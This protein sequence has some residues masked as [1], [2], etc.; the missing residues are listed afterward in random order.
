[1]SNY[2]DLKIT[3]ADLELDKLLLESSEH[4]F[5]PAFFPLNADP[6]TEYMLK[7]KVN[8]PYTASRFFGQIMYYLD[9][10][11]MGI[12]EMEIGPTQ[13]IDQDFESFL[14]EFNELTEKYGLNRYRPYEKDKEERRNLQ[15]K[16][17]SFKENRIPV[18]LFI[19]EVSKVED[20]DFDLAILDEDKHFMISHYPYTEKSTDRD[21]DNILNHRIL[22]IVI[23]EIESY[24][25]ETGYYATILGY[26]IKRK[27]EVEENVN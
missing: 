23:S 12:K 21:L 27:S 8:N 15:K 5:P 3:E 26:G 24:K 2:I 20:I 10:N 18:Y 17:D 22:P 9:R 1:M 25:I 19:E 7:F 16:I 11:L 13:K 14:K 6:E 4:K